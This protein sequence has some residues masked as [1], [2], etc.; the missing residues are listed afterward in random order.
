MRSLTLTRAEVA[1]VTSQKDN[2]GSSNL[3]ID[4]ENGT[5]YVATARKGDEGGVDIEIISLTPGGD[6]GY[7]REVRFNFP[8]I[9]VHLS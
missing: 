6:G 4:P 8:D 3:A 2:V 9:G 7:I 1:S 5:L